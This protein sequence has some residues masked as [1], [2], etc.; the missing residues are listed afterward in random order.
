MKELTIVKIGKEPGWE[1][2]RELG[3]ELSLGRKEEKGAKRKKERSE[4][5]G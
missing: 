3:R 5:I 2:G 1:L 4:G